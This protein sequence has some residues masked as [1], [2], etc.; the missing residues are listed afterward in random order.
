[1]MMGSLG[2][3]ELFLVN[4]LFNLYLLTLSIRLILAFSRS[5]YFNPL[6]QLIIK[7]TQPLVAPLRRILP[8]YKGVEYATLVLMIF[9]E[10]I[11][12][13]LVSMITIGVPPIATLLIFALAGTLRVILSTFFY[14]ILLRAILSWFQPGYSP[15]GQLL[16]ELSAPIIRPLQRI[17]PSINGIDITPIPALIIL[18]L[19]IILL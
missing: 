9:F 2:N 19:L 10:L 3:A 14:A 11:R 6:T 13:I 12:V 18:Q 5:N 1:M 16:E 4:T 8:T 7:L 15:A 17:I